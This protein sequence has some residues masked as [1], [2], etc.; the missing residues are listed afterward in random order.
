[1]ILK[2][3]ILAI[4]QG[5]TEFLPV[6]SS[7]HL[8]FL[9]HFFGIK[10][11]QLVI[12]VVLHFGTLFSIL[13]FFK[14][15]L[16]KIANISYFKNKENVLKLIYVIIAIIP[17]GIVGVLL[18]DLIEAKL[19]FIHFVGI[20]WIINGINLF[21]L[22][23]YDK[24]Q[25]KNL[26]LVSSLIVG[27][28]QIF[29]IL[30]GISRSGTTIA[31]GVY[32]GMS[33]KLSAKFSFFI[34][35]PIIFG[36]SV[37]KIKDVIENPANFDILALLIGFVISFIVGYLSLK[38]LFSVLYNKKIKYFAYYSLLIGIISLFL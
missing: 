4:I 20:M 24:K 17:A 31:T 37:L 12:D 10:Q 6:S 13:L 16:V 26:N 25:K 19:F 33:R 2:I 14:K 7:G 9:Q 36:A 22:S 15:D 21:I 38:L 8:V 27:L 32:S 5:I 18:N 1:M 23:K 29:A 34:A 35:I 30:P 11:N 28:S 3:I